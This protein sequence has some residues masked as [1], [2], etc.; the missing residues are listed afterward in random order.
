MPT[1]P[2]TQ[3]IY[4][5]QRFLISDNQ[6]NPIAWEV[7]KIEDT[8]PLGIIYVTIKQDLFNPATD[9]KELMIA[10]YYKSQVQPEKPDKKHMI[11]FNAPAAVKVGGAF[12]TFSVT[13]PLSE[14]SYSWIIRGL[15]LNQYIVDESISGKI[16]IKM[17]KNYSL[18]GQA[19]TLDLY[20][21]GKLSDSIQVEVA[22]L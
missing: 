20:T 21:N 4:Y 18:I 15:D 9:N 13:D 8:M 2:E 11:K 19:F 14:D 7:S 5:N 10:D 6:V 1:N 17:V 16:K 12:K 3:T 22:S